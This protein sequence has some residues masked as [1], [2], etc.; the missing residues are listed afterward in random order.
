LIKRKV[1]NKIPF[2][3]N[4]NDPAKSHADVYFHEDLQKNNITCFL[5]TSVFCI[6][7]NKNWKKLEQF[8]NL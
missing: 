1:I 5:D 7:L 2:R 4:M 8:K 3:V 6:H